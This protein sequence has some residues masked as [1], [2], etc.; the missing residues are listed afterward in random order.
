MH[1]LKW[2]AGRVSGVYRERGLPGLLRR[3]FA[4]LLCCFFE[5]RT[6]YLTGYNLESLPQLDEAAFVPRVD[7]LSFRVVCSNKDP[8]ALEA[9]CLEFASASGDFRFDARRALDGGAIACCIY[10][11]KEL[12]SIGWI[13]LTRHAMDSLN[14]RRMRIDFARGE[15]FTGNMWTNPKYRGMGLR[16]YRMYKKR[17]L[18]AEKGI[19]ATRGYAAKRNVDAVRGIGRIDSTVDGEARYLRILWWKSWRETPLTQG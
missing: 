5:Y 10:V 12:A 8:D 6:F 2:L 14:E 4:F 15:S 7:G 13:A 19:K 11:G 16:L 3:G 1:E 17:R 18:L 9:E